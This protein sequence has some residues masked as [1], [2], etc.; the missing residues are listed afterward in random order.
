MQLAKKIIAAC[1]DFLM[2]EAAFHRKETINKIRD[3]SVPAA[4]HLILIYL[5][6]D[7]P[8][9]NHWK[10]ELNSFAVQV[11]DFINT[12][13][14]RLSFSALVG[15][16]WEEPLGETSDRNARLKTLRKKYLNQD[17]LA[18]NSLES[19]DFKNYVIDWIKSIYE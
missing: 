8:A 7:S 12:K 6:K 9:V 19:E 17:G 2:T 11:E 1:E 15:L 5:L 14:G 4:K 13:H 10:A 3:V 18:E 16:L